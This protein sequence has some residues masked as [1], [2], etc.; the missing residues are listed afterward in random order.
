MGLGL[1]TVSLGLGLSNDGL[2]NP[3]GQLEELVFGVVSPIPRYVC[4][5]CACSA[6]IEMWL[7]ETSC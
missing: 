6:S 4:V 7:P 1:N 3:T 2:H 5:F